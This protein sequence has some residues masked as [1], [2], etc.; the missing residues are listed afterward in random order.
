MNVVNPGHNIWELLEHRV[1]TEPVLPHFLWHGRLAAKGHEPSEQLSTK[2]DPP[3]AGWTADV[4]TATHSREIFP[5]PPAL[6]RIQKRIITL[7]PHFGGKCKI[8]WFAEHKQSQQ[9]IKCAAYSNLQPFFC[10]AATGMEG[11][12]IRLWYMLYR[13]SRYLDRESA[14]KKPSSRVPKCSLKC[15]SYPPGCKSTNP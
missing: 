4:A 10:K 11:T 6:D 15:C 5:A 7:I 8:F 13:H 2:C 1:K 12:V 14:E 3:W 9:N